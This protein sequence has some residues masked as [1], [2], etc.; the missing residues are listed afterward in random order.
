MFSL[1]WKVL[2]GPVEVDGQHLGCPQEAL[3]LPTAPRPQGSD[4]EPAMASLGLPDIL[5]QQVKVKSVLSISTI[6][7]EEFS[8]AW[9]KEI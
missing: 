9:V 6:R 1:G 5:K 3:L 8:L 7:V 4:W 2:G